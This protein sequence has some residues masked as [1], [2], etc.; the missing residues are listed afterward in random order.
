M[1]RK[2]KDFEID[3]AGLAVLLVSDDMRAA[4]IVKYWS[5]QTTI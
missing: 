3:K 5:I 1:A 4:M 2:T